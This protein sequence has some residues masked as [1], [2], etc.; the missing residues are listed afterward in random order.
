MPAYV[1][2]PCAANRLLMVERKPCSCPS[3]LCVWAPLCAA[4]NIEMAP[5]IT[6]AAIPRKAIASNRVAPT[7]LVRRSFWTS[8]I[9]PHSRRKRP[10]SRSTTTLRDI[11]RARC[12]RSA[13]CLHRVGDDLLD[14]NHPVDQ[15]ADHTGHEGHGGR[16]QHLGLGL[17]A[18]DAL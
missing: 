10:Q 18:L 1:Y 11:R 3:M 9:S 8:L 14:R 12:A 15:K 16:V 4:M 2:V 7:C 13:R 17:H 5:T 6:I